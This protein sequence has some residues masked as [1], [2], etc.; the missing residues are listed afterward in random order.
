HRRPELSSSSSS[1][2]SSSFGVRACAIASGAAFIYFIIFQTPHPAPTPA[3]LS[4]Q[5]SRALCKAVA[6]VRK[7]RRNH[8]TFHWADHTIKRTRGSCHGVERGQTYQGETTV[9]KWGGGVGVRRNP[10]ANTYTVP[11]FV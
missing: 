4:K 8:I 10:P 3:P 6:R 9:G 7:A 5:L 1:S 2:S 11:S